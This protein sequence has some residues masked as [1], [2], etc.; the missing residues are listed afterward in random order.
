[1]TRLA[2]NSSQAEPPSAVDC[3]PKPEARSVI[4]GA[5]LD[6]AALPRLAGRAQETASRIYH[7]GSLIVKMKL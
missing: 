1:M 4:P 2:A 5:P 6:P 7:C 3:Y